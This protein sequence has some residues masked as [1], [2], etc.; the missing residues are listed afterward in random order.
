I[1]TALAIARE[2]EIFRDDSFAITGA[3]LE[4]LSDEELAASVSKYSVYARVAPE[5]KVRIVRAW[6]SHDQIVAM[7]GDGVNDAPALK[8]A[9]IGA[10]MGI[11]GTDVAKGAADMVLTDD[12]FATIVSAVE[13]GRRIYDNILKAIQFLISCNVGEI[14]LLLVTSLFNLGAPLLPIHILWVNLVTDSFPALALSFDP[15]GK[16]IMKRKPRQIRSGFMTKGM[17]YRI[18]YQGLMIGAI[19]LAAFLIG[20]YEEDL[21]LGQT[22]AFATLMLAQL[23]HVR[24]IHSNTKLSFT[25]NPLDNKPLIG[26][27]LLSAALALVVLLVPPVRDIFKLTGMDGKHWV[28]VIL[29]SFIP[30]LVVNLFKLFKINTIKEEKQE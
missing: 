22:M 5:H 23:T 2:L 15:A 9:D 13:E 14:F 17:V 18:F 20:L 30:I 4:K 8:Q 7:T 29:M 11:V 21:V 3:E 16:D 28:I 25:I 27:I 1:N 12:N 26:A 10:A 24:N 6:Q 19:P